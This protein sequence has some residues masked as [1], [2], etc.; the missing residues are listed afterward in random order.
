MSNSLD[1]LEKFYAKNRREWHQW[2]K[3]HYK[4][5]T[6]SLAHLL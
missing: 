5:F 2:L 3:E 4:F 1:Q 6:R